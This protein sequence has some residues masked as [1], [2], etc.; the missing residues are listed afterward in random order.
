LS[1]TATLAP[2]IM[3][4]L[5]SATVPMMLPVGACAVTMAHTMKIVEAFPFIRI[6]FY[7]STNCDGIFS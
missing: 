6:P 7:E 2:A 1:T 3:P 5:E 4:P